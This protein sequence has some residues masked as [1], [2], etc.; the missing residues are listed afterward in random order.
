MKAKTTAKPLKNPI[1]PGRP[2]L[3]HAECGTG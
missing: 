1:N 2:L 3:C